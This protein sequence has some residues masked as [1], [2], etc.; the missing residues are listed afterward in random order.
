M[1]ILQENMKKMQRIKELEAKRRKNSKAKR[2]ATNEQRMKKR[3]IQR[4]KAKW[5]VKPFHGNTYTDEG[6]LEYW[7][8][9]GNEA[10]CPQCGPLHC[11]AE[12]AKHSTI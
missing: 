9:E 6:S 4:E 1:F 11:L 7:D 10:Q 2:S 8:L 12:K 5:L 3:E